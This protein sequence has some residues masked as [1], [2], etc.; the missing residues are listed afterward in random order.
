MI[1]N[2]GGYAQKK[3]SGVVSARETQSA[4]SIKMDLVNSSADGNRI[5]VFM[6]IT[7][8][9]ENQGLDVGLIFLIIVLVIIVLLVILGLVFFVQRKKQKEKLKEQYHQ[10]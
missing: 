4:I 1:E 10:G 6:K 8:N 2:S 5:K 7:K 9:P 3:F